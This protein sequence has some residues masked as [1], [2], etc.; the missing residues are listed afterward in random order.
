MIMKYFAV[1]IELNGDMEKLARHAWDILSNK[2]SIKYISSRSPCP[3]FSLGGGFQGK[4][5]DVFEIM[6]RVGEQSQPFSIMGNGLGVFVRATPVVHIRWIL[7]ENLTRLRDC[8]N[9]QLINVSDI[10]HSSSIKGF[11]E[12]TDWVPKAT[13]AFKDSTYEKL[14]EILKFVRPLKFD[15]E[16][17]V[18]RIAL[19]KFS[20]KD[21]DERLGYV[22]FK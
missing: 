18:D 14:Y 19:Y 3:H 5:E 9:E 13:L 20:I 6:Q 15:Q 22:N 8:L 7:N 11:I 17:M 2:L 10:N 16:I 1:V 12:N 21:G 4:P